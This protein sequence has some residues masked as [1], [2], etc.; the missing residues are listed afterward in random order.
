MQEKIA[1]LLQ[2]GIKPLEILS[3]VA[4]SVYD[5]VENNR[6]G[7]RIIYLMLN[8]YETFTDFFAAKNDELD[9][10]DRDVLAEIEDNIRYYVDISFDDHEDYVKQQLQSGALA[11]EVKA[12]LEAR[13]ITEPLCD[14][15]IELAYAEAFENYDKLHQA[16]LDKV[17]KLSP[18]KAYDQALADRAEYRKKHHILFDDADFIAEYNRTFD[19]PAL[20]NL[21]KDRLKQAFTTG[22]HYHIWDDGV[23]DEEDDAEEEEGFFEPEELPEGEE[24]SNEILIADGPMLPGEYDYVCQM[25][26]EYTG[27]RVLA[28]ENQWGTGSYWTTYEDDFQELI[29]YFVLEHFEDLV[30]ELAEDRPVEWDSFGRILGLEKA[31]RTSAIAV[32]DHSDKINYFLSNLNEQLWNE[33]SESKL[34]EYLESVK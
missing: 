12:D 5:V 13:G 11:K 29:S 19:R 6:A 30:A 28:A 1:A 26:T 21:L 31:D 32:L 16:F 4:G 24:D 18:K 33:F 27:R 14:D 9:L 7:H 17:M 23:L 10:S 3:L 25:M 20:W 34:S 22:Q 8:E 2:D 15:T